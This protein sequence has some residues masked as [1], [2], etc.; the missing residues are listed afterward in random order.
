MSEEKFLAFKGL[1]QYDPGMGWAQV[2]KF[3]H[4]QSE[5]AAQTSAEASSEVLH[6]PLL[7]ELFE[8]LN[9]PAQDE[10]AQNWKVIAGSVS[11]LSQRMNQQRELRKRLSTI[12]VELDTL[13]Q[14]ILKDLQEIQRSADQQLSMARLRAEVSSLAQARL[15]SRLRHSPP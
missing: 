3:N 12:D 9:R 11:L 4:T 1:K 15:A 8:Q 7:G 2:H 14:T 10:L 6:D 13:R 5:E